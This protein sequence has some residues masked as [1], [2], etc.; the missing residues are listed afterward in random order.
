MLFKKTLKA[1]MIQI[2]SEDILHEN[3]FSA[4]K[5]KQVHSLFGACF[6]MTKCG[7]LVG[8]TLAEVLITLLIIGVVSAITIPTLINNYQK[9]QY[10]T[11]LKKAYSEFNQ[12]LAQIAAD[13]G[14]PGDLKCAGF[15][16]NDASSQ[17]FGDELVKYYKVATNCGITPSG[18]CFA[19]TTKEYYDGSGE[20]LDYD[21]S[22]NRYKFIT[23][24]G[25]SFRFGNYN[26][27]NCQNNWSTGATRH[28][29]ETCGMLLIDTNGPTKG[30]NWLGRDIFN[31]FITNGNGPLLY[32]DGG[33]DD[34]YNN[35]NYWW[36]DSSKIPRACIPG[37]KYGWRCAGRIMEESWQMN[38]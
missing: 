13:A 14:C 28:M 24:D 9:T 7:E 34:N 21:A 20:G 35:I 3:K 36:K 17:R 15:F 25:I 31:F 11:R 27:N 1:S 32:P 10:V 5:V 6:R 22:S 8:F 2:N 23:V 16:E 18:G 33:E 38:Y 19:T 4:K 12:V 26:N 30:P 37:N 29:K